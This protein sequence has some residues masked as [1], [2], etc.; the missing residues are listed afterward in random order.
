MTSPS[1]PRATE[2]VLV[3]LLRAARASGLNG[4]TRALQRE[5]GVE[6][7]L[8]DRN[9]SV[10]AAAPSRYLWDPDAI[11]HGEA[12]GV[13]LRD[14]HVNGEPVATLA[15]NRAERAAV[16]TVIVEVAVDLIGLEVQ[17]LLDSQ[18]IRR[19]IVANVID[20]IL[21]KRISDEDADH[22][23]QTLGVDL[24]KPFRVLLGVADVPNQRRDKI[25]WGGLH[26]AL[27][28]THDPFLRVLRGDHSLMV[29]PD[30]QMVERIAATQLR[31]L[32]GI[33]K[34]VRVGLSLSHQGGLGLRIAY[35]EAL[36]AL[37]AG[38]GLN[39]PRVLNLP[40]LLVVA[41][42][43]LPLTDL[44]TDILR[45]IIEYDDQHGSDLVATLRG[46]LEHH[47]NVQAA[48]EALFI[49]RNTLR[50]RLRQITELLE[51]D[52]DQSPIIANLWIALRVL[53]ESD[54]EGRSNER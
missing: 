28:K 13:M 37:R 1:V 46:Y 12:D 43:S 4:I 20:D 3:R 31:H 6:V 40:D 18:V 52:L 41:N 17:R 29:L 32:Q 16:D 22:R 54:Q 42:D 45:P 9:G 5:L 15:W 34:N 21:L 50:Y 2:D 24:S 39:F 23:V 25:I 38:P 33:G 11:L 47:R 8:F 27:A 19:E 30:D 44:A 51:V 49:H 48:T 10:L 35:H 53:D 26:S 36:S 7:G 14:I